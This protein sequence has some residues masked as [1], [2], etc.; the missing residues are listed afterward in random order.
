MC[1]LL[2][3]TYGEW[4]DCGEAFII[5]CMGPLASPRM[6]GAEGA[7]T[8]RKKLVC[9]PKVSQNQKTWA[10]LQILQLCKMLDNVSPRLRL[11]CRSPFI[12]TTA[13]RSPL[14]LPPA[15]NVLPP[16]HRSVQQTTYFDLTL[17]SLS[18]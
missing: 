18:V 8:T 11:A 15:E 14:H 12:I 10:L 9:W 6:A 13:A 16:F 7:F 4:R 1:S 17:S 3:Q 5:R 2:F